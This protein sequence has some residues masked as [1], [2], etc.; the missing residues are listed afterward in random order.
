MTDRV[1]HDEEYSD[2]ELVEQFRTGDS[3]A[4]QELYDR[5]YNRIFRIVFHYTGDTD[6]TEDIVHDVFIRVLR[7]MDSFNVERKFSSWIYRIAV[8]C[9]KNDINRRVKDHDLTE[10]VRY[11]F[12]DEPVKSRSP[13]D[14]IIEKTELHELEQAVR[15]L[16]DRFRDV[17]ILRYTEGMPYRDIARVMKCSERTA[18]WRMKRALQ[19]IHHYLNER[20][21]L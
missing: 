10:Q 20:G 13:E 17:F 18:K 4:F 6:M 16:G 19:Q 21:M 8:N 7:H 3:A 11:R 14:Q 15:E 5:Y 9:S 12:R 1:Y 2:E